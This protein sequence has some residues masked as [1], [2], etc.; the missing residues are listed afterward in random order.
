MLLKR[1]MGTEIEDRIALRD[2]QDALGKNIPIDDELDLRPSRLY[3]GAI[4]N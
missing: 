2:G 4:C 1:C 3:R